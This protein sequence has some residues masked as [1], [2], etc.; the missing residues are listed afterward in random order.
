M[1]SGLTPATDIE[2]VISNSRMRLTA[3]IVATALFM[4]N[5]DSTVI[6]TALPA[7][8][9]T[10]H[11]DPL[12]MSIAL[13]SYLISLS[14][15]IPASGWVAD[16][17]GAK[18]VFRVAI[19]I[20]TVAS[21]FCGLAPSL[22]ILIAARV[23]Q[24]LGGA[25]MLPVGRLVLLRSVSRAQMVS[26]MSWLTMP[27]LI[28]PIM[29]PPLGGFIVTYFS[30][31][32]VFEI[33]VPIGIA[34]IVAVSIFITDVREA[35]G[36]GKLDLLGL[37]LTGFA[38]AALMAGFETLGREIVPLSWTLIALAAGAAASFAYI[39][40]AKRNAN[41]ILDFSLMR[42]A[43]FSSS[44]IAGSLFRVAV[45]AVPFLLPLMLQLGF[46]ETPMQSGLV[47]F[48]SAAGALAMKPAAQ[49]VLHRFGFRAV[50]VVNGIL[51]AAFIMVCALF[52][53]YWP[54]LVM[55]IILLIGGFFR[56]LQFTAF[57]AIAYGDI[58]RNKMSAATTLYSTI[59]QLTLTMGIVIG[60]ATL[61]ISARL[62]HH[63]TA[64][65]SDY[66]MGF[67]VVGGVALLAIPFCAR[68][69]SD[70]GEALSG[71]HV[72]SLPK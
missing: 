18:N 7:M 23:L 55:D 32:W 46:G 60:A 47:T 65:R 45:G 25:M 20:F 22:P 44:V 37:V 31:R 56:S 50:L 15:F 68:L 3:V 42:I 28:G 14:V 53:P 38:M 35:G 6:A 62:H 4:Q 67:W 10:Y 17:F 52:Q 51:S 5:L 12:H 26:A 36:G 72:A 54:A 1:D 29:G 58:A 19:L 70:A 2:P 71:H 8:A 41:P 63:A 40:H 33:N 11:A 9:K 43:T 59:Q 49:P 27:A 64:L 48:A 30:W 66:A 24:G 69:R 39:L 61:E 16:H 34:G 13:T 21:V 57:N